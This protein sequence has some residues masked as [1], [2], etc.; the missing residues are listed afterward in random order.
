M[1]HFQ[2]SSSSE[3][4]PVILD[5]GPDL[6][7]FRQVAAVTN[8]TVSFGQIPREDWFQPDWIDE[9]KAKAG[10]DALTRQGII[11]GGGSLLRRISRTPPQSLIFLQI[12]YRM[13]S[14][15]LSTAPKPLTILSGTETCADSNRGRFT[16]KS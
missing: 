7:E 16:S 1:S 3:F 8:S 14:P 5:K 2:R 6:E 13:R 10:R 11:Y 12:V 15:F 9:E 4:I